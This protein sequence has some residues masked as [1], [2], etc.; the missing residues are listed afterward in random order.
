MKLF[1][2]KE[3]FRGQHSSLCGKAQFFS[4]S[5]NYKIKIAKVE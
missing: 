2:V 5:H 4:R 3:N 1:K